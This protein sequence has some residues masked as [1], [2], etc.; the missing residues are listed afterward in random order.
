MRYALL[1]AVG[2]AVFAAAPAEAQQKRGCLTEREA[3]AEQIIRHGV[4]LREGSGRCEAMGFAE[5]TTALWRDL[6]D[7]MAQFF[8]AEMDRR[9]RAFRREFAEHADHELLQWN[10]RI[11]AHFR[12]RPLD[13]IYC[14]RLSNQLAQF[15]ATGWAAFKK[16]AENERGEVRMDYEVCR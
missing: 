5:G 10:G 16:Q 6:E 12:H 3:L 11:V 7:Q 1:V 9:I 14:R 4:R 8:R 2:F 15:G 13:A